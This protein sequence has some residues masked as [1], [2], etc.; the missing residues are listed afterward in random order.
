MFASTIRHLIQTSFASSFPIDT[1]KL[2]NCFPY[3]FQ[4]NLS[5]IRSFP[6]SIPGNLGDFSSHTAPIQ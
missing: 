3:H 4:R 2:M 1:A 5:S 6:M